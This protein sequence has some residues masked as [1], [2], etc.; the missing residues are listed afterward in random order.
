MKFPKL[1]WALEHMESHWRK[2]IW[3]E[4]AQMVEYVRQ[5][6]WRRMEEEGRMSKH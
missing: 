6:R 2:W 1:W 4:E 3:V 5:K